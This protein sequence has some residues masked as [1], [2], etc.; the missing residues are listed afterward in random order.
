M[1]PLSEIAAGRK[2]DSTAMT[3]WSSSSG[4]LYLLG[5]APDVLAVGGGSEQDGLHVGRRDGGRPGRGRRPRGLA[6]RPASRLPTQRSR[7][8]FP[9][10]QTPSASLQAKVSPAPAAAGTSASVPRRSM[11]ASAGHGPSRGYRPEA[12]RDNFR[13]TVLGIAAMSTTSREHVD[14]LVLGGGVAGLSFAL[15]AARHGSRARPDQ[16]ATARRA[17]PSTPRAA[18]PRCSAPDD[19]F[20]LHVEDTLVAGAGLCHREAVEVT[21]PRRRRSGSAGSSRWASSSTGRRRTGSTSPARAATRA[22][23]S[24]TPRTPPAA[25][26]E[27]AL[28]AACA[29]RR[30]PH[31]GGPGGHRPHHQRASRRWP[32]RTGRWAPTCSTGPPAPSRTIPAGGDRARHRRR[33]QGLPLHRRTPTSATGDGVAMAYRAGASVAN[34]EFF[35]FHPTCLFHPRRQELPHLRGAARRGRHP[36]QQGGRGLHD[37]LRPAQGAGARAT[38]WPAPSTPR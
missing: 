5:G 32:A 16:A 15:E 28:L 19:E 12:P 29:A 33:R 25:R 23:A 1:A 22:A 21:V 17:T 20:A 14:F 38:S 2:L 8:T 3:A 30:H 6:G 10:T 27:R 13:G 24:P 7:S 18:S 37:P 9:R 4:S 34:M 26:S 11:A 31:R 35:Q 36:A